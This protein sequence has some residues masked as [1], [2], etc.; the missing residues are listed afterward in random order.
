M[1][2]DHQDRHHRHG[3]K[4]GAT[5]HRSGPRLQGDRQQWGGGER[6]GEER[7][8]QLRPQAEQNIRS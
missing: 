2:P 3:A 8:Q 1:I 7:L 6:A 5:H 4:G